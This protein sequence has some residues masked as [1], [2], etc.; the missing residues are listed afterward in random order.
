MNH[1]DPM[2]AVAPLEND[3]KADAVAEEAKGFCRDFPGA[4]QDGSAGCFH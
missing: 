3:P 2:L 4:Q 1:I